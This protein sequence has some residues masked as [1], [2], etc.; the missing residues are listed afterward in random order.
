MIPHVFQPLLFSNTIRFP[1]F[2]G[3]SEN[4]DPW[5][6]ETLPWNDE[7]GG[8]SYKQIWRGVLSA[9]LVLDAG[10]QVKGFSNGGLRACIRL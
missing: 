9:K 2:L 1:W 7:F 5:T 4:N 6:M 8:F 10:D 3:V